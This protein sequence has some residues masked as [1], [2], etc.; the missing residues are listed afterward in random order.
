LISAYRHEE[1]QLAASFGPPRMV[2]IDLQLG[3]AQMIVN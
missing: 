2:D 3:N 1:Q